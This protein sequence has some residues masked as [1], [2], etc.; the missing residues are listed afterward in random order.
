MDLW[1][2]LALTHVAAQ[3]PGDASEE[4]QALAARFAEGGAMLT[5]RARASLIE[6]GYSDGQLETLVEDLRTDVGIQVESADIED[7]FSFE[8]CQALLPI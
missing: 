5:D 4:Q 3:A 2:G 8:E 7:E 6:N 1:C